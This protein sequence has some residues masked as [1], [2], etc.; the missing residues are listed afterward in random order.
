MKISFKKSLH[1]LALPNSSAHRKAEL[2][3]PFP[4]KNRTIQLFFYRHG[5]DEPAQNRL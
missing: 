4:N 2:L 5:S 3:K 1:R